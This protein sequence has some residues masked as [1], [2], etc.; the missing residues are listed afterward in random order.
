MS[1][2]WSIL[3]MSV[4]VDYNIIFGHS[5]FLYLYTIFYTL[6]ATQGQKHFW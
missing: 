5:C 6:V 4:T 2:Q 1:D 3:Q